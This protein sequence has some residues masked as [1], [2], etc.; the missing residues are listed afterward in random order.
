MSF[1]ARDLVRFTLLVTDE[2]LLPPPPVNAPTMSS[3]PNMATTF[4]WGDGLD[5][6]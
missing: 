1:E 2:L 4:G 3:I 6:R 5:E